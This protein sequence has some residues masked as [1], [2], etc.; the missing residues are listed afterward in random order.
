MAGLRLYSIV[1]IALLFLIPMAALIGF[2]LLGSRPS[3]RPP[4]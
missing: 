1:L 2:G 4:G 3:V